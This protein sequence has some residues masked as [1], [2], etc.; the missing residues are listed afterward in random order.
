MAPATRFAQPAGSD[1]ARCA[2]QAE[3]LSGSDTPENVMG[4]MIESNIN[5]GK[6][7]IG[8]GGRARWAGQSGLELCCR[9]DHRLVTASSTASA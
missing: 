7:S 5:E 1:E 6:Q 4:V 9:T 8:S 2:K 3:Q